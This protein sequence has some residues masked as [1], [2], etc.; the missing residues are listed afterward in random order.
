VSPPRFWLLKTEPDT[1]SFDDL[2]AAPDRTTLWE[3][4]RNF[5]ARNLMRDDM[6]VGDRALIYHSSCQPPGAVGV[7]EVVRDAYPDPTQFDPESPY[8]D[9]K[10][11]PDAPRWVAVDVRAVE[12]LPRPVSLA[13]MKRDPA[14]AGTKLVTRGN[15]LSVV[16]LTKEEFERVL[17]LSR[18]RKE[19]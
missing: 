3:G 1:F 16:P 12:G 15:R 17:G 10:A 4:V 18:T 11:R 5:E 6:R 2:L 9:P 14:L 7:A 8:L 13:E 19:G